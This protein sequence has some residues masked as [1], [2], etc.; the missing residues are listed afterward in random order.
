MRFL[1]LNTDYEEYLHGLYAEHPG[2]ES[3]SFE[4]QMRVRSDSLFGVADFYSSNLKK[5]GHEAYDFYA[6]N[7]SMQSAWAQENGLKIPAPPRKLRLNLR[8][9]W[10][11]WVSRNG[12]DRSWTGIL[13]EQ[14]KRYRPDVVLNQAL[15]EIDTDFLQR[16]RGHIRLLVGQHAATTLPDRYQWSL[17]DLIIS[18]FPPTVEWVRQR[19]I[20]AVLNR[21]AFEPS[22]LGRVNE[23][24]RTIPLSFVGSFYDVHRPRTALLEEIAARLPLS[25]W[26]PPPRREL[27][28]SRLAKCY[29]GA[30]WGLDM[31]RILARSKITVNH[32]GNVPPFANNMRLYEATGM[33]ALLVTDWKENLH[34]MFEPGKEV[35]VYRTTEECLEQIDYYLKHDQ[36]REAIA[37]AGQQRTLREHTYLARVQELVDVVEKH[38]RCAPPSRKS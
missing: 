22:V 31:Y 12:T 1:I 36:E 5:L 20:P 25:I 7:G 21:L 27:S 26:G 14:I 11:P 33:G 6:N 16:I 38:L 29:R 35:V 13:E 28:R 15:H 19:N 3:A 4:E 8:G 32:H 24:V 17:Y 23:E 9:G 37:R 30:A 18:S 34:E 10:L 2:L